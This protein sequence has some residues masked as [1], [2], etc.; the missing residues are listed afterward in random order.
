M[1]FFMNYLF[2]NIETVSFNGSD[3]TKQKDSALNIVYMFKHDENIKDI[4]IIKWFL[5]G[6]Q[7]FL[8]MH[9][10]RYKFLLSHTQYSETRVSALQA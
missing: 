3:A 10:N 7:H 2:H 5:N 6:L 8:L 1:T 4:K 9:L